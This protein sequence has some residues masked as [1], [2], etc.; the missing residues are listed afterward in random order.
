MK[1]P[2]EGESP[3]EARSEKQ[4]FRLT[5]EGKPPLR[6]LIVK[7]KTNYEFFADM[8]ESEIVRFFRLC[9]RLSVK[10]GEVIFEEGEKGEEFYL[11][12]FGGVAIFV[13]DREVSRL[14]AGQC[15]GEMAILEDAPRNATVKVVEDTL[16][17]CVDR[18]ILTNV[19]PGL[20]FKIAT[21]LARQLS[22]K[23]RDTDKLLADT[24]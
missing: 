1:D 12:V 4:S 8:S 13:G 5:R 24:D 15:F 6:E 11:I 9:D 22:D 3:E 18:G 23:L 2:E 10:P 7:L 17:F 14:G 21:S 20:G 19:L 16:L